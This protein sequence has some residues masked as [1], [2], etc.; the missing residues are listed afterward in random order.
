MKNLKIK[1]LLS[2]VFIFIVSFSCFAYKRYYSIK[3]YNT[4]SLKR[5]WVL[6]NNSWHYYRLG[7]LVSDEIV[8]SGDKLFFINYDGEVDYTEGKIITNE[9]G[10]YFQITK[11]GSLNYLGTFEVDSYFKD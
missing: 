9:Q 1:L 2:L 5:G 11:D 7:E 6:E 8:K 10:K 4:N 3:N